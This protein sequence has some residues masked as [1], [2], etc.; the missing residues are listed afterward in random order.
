MSAF[1]GYVH[2]RKSISRRNTLNCLLLRLTRNKKGKERER[3]K[4]C[5]GCV[6]VVVY[7]E[8]CRCFVEKVHLAEKQFAWRENWRE[9]EV[10][11]YVVTKNHNVYYH[12]TCVCTCVLTMCKADNVLGPSIPS[13]HQKN[14]R[15]RQKKKVLLLGVRK[16]CVSVCTCLHVEAWLAG[17][18]KAASSKVT[19]TYQH[20]RTQHEDHKPFQCINT[21][22]LPPAWCAHISIPA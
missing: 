17:L 21:S 3:K 22:T 9:R 10:L 12:V 4:T 16:C 6:P 14:N 5:L 11:L 15:H 8:V 20:W 18:L 2:T 19:D 7:S 1:W 13:L